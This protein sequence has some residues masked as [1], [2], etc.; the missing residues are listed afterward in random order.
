MTIQRRLFAIGL[1][2]SSLTAFSG[3]APSRALTEVSPRIVAELKTNESFALGQPL[4]AGDPGRAL[5]EKVPRPIQPAGTSPVSSS[6]QGRVLA[7]LF[8][9]PGAIVAAITLVLTVVIC[10]P[11]KRR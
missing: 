8:T 7:R 9:I 3:E 6:T 5:A 4:S 11:R 1:S 10:R 2:L